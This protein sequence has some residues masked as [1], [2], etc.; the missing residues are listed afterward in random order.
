[1]FF[2]EKMTP[3]SILF[4]KDHLS[5]VNRVLADSGV[6]HITESKVEE[7]SNYDVHSQVDR[8]KQLDGLVQNLAAFAGL[9]LRY[10][11]NS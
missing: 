7:F 11:A 4:H 2:P 8:I 3:I 10:H 1:M 9:E 5:E 6:L